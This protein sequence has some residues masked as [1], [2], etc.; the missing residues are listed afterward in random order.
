MQ[1]QRHNTAPEPHA[2]KRKHAI[3]TSQYSSWATETMHLQRRN[4]VPGPQKPCTYNVTI[5]LL[6]RINH[7][8]TTSQYSSWATE[9]MHLQRRHTAP[10][11]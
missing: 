11:P 9:T 1:F 5:Q 6:S 3:S 7:A 10:E 4:T 8:L 2:H